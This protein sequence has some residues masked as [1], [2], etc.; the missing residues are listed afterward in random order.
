MISVTARNG[1]RAL[2]YIAKEST[3][4]RRVSLAEVAKAVDAPMPY[5]GK[6]LQV[7]TKHRLLSSV[8]GPGGGFYFS[9]VQLQKTVYDLLLLIEEP[10][11]VKGCV[12]G[13]AACS[14]EEPCPVHEHIYPL[15]N[16]LLHFLR[17]TTIKDLADKVEDGKTFLQLT[18]E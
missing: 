18:V 4:N 16:E 13:L 12:L 8:K 17:T 5:L 1:I 2:I 7:V 3:C 6:I 10:Y 11:W 14:N 9:I 15:K